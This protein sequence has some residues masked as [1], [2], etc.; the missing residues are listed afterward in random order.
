MALK[1]TARKCNTKPKMSPKPA[2]GCCTKLPK[3]HSSALLPLRRHPSPHRG[4]GTS[5]K[6]LAALVA[7]IHATFLF[8]LQRP[9]HGDAVA[10][11]TETPVQRLR[12]RLR[13]QFHLLPLNTTDGDRDVLGAQM[14]KGL[15]PHHSFMTVREEG[16]QIT[17]TACSTV[18]HKFPRVDRCVPFIGT[19]CRRTFGRTTATSFVP[20]TLTAAFCITAFTA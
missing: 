17:G 6:R 12:P 7:L 5:A 2:P 9:G 14:R 3:H 19:L 15:P 8:S 18:F 20:C 13:E 11:S 1:E 16:S 4:P 10:I